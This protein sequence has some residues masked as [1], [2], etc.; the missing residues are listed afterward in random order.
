[1][2]IVER[3]NDISKNMLGDICINYNFLYKPLWNILDFSFTKLTW[4]TPSKKDLSQRIVN[5][6]SSFFRIE[7]RAINDKRPASSILKI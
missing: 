4:N 7:C 2:L 6:S 3:K 1:M 5:I